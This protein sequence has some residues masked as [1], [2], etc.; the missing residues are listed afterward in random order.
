VSSGSPSFPASRATSSLPGVVEAL[1]GGIDQ[2]PVFRNTKGLIAGQLDKA[3][4]DD[5]TVMPELAG[6]L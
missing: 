5:R 3:I 6:E 1:H 4:T 2:I